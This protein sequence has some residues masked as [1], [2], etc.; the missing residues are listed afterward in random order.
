M[1]KNEEQTMEKCRKILKKMKKKM[2]YVE[3][4]LTQKSEAYNENGINMK[5]Q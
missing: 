4:T 5:K 1:R 2:E 3:Q